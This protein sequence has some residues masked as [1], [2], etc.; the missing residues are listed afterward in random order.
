MMQQLYYHIQQLY[1]IGRR[2]TYIPKKESVSIIFIFKI[3]S[4][5]RMRLSLLIKKLNFGTLKKPVHV[6]KIDLNLY[7]T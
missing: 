4:V 7:C 6:N 5:T 2:T 1:I 3:A